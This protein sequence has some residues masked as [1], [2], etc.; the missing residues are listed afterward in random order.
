MAI[1]SHTPLCIYLPWGWLWL[2]ADPIQYGWSWAPL[3]WTPK[4]SGRHTPHST[5]EERLVVAFE[6]YAQGDNS[7]LMAW[8]LPTTVG[9]PF[10]QAAWRELLTIPQGTI[11]TYGDLAKRVAQQ[12]GKR[13]APQAVGQA[14]KNNPWPLRVPCHRVIST[15]EQRGQTGFVGYA[16]Q[17]EGYLPTIKTQLLAWERQQTR[18]LVKPQVL[19]PTH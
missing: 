18:N 5:D 1:E 3:T 8:P 15:A 6:A 4:T 19:I 2:N 16:G 11:A 12:T 14:C 7:L 9:T 13:P 10:Q 17:T